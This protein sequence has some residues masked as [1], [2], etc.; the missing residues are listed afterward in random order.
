M[1]KIKTNLSICPL[2]SATGLF[3]HQGRDLLYDKNEL[4]SYDECT[5]CFAIYHRPMPDSKTISEFYPDA[6]YQEITKQKKHSLI[7]QSVLKT[8]YNYSHIQIPS[9]LKIIAPIISFFYYKSSIQFR[10][11]SKGL[12]IGCGNGRFI[13]SM[14]SLGW[15][16]EGVEFSSVAVDICHKAGLKVFNGEL[17]AANFENNS[18]DLISARHLIEHIP[19]PDNLFKEISRILKPKGRLIIRTPNSR[20][21]GRKWFGLNWFPDD[22]PRHLILFDLKNL[23]MLAKNHNLSYVKSKTFASPRAILNSID[24]FTENKKTPSRKRKLHKFLAKFFVA[25]ATLINK[26]DELFVIYE[27]K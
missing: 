9:Y 25:F 18:F 4:Y 12:D 21:L 16:F 27:K 6:Y 20:A 22:I 11:D 13:S 8:R 19:D 3:S 15:Q 1:N 10:P 2:C 26:G 5:R 7:K 24:Y 23:N 14:N 17:K